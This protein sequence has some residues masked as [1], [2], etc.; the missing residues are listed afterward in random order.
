[1]ARF[2]ESGAFT[3]AR[4]N[5]PRSRAS[6]PA[7]VGPEEGNEPA[8]LASAAITKITATKMGFRT[9]ILTRLQSAFAMPR[10]VLEIAGG[11]HRFSQ[12]IGA[13]PWSGP[14]L[15]AIDAR[16]KPA[17]RSFRLF[18]ERGNLFFRA[19]DLGFSTAAQGQKFLLTAEIQERRIKF[20]LL[21]P[22]GG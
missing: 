21:P 2:T 14:P 19:G 9:E 1:M 12:S 6:F 10:S 15:D 3:G 4:A 18:V 17:V 11:H 16:R 5:P 22:S 7:V 13:Q 8:K 20:C